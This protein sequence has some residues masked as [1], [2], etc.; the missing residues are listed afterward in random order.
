MAPCHSFL[1]A[2]SLFTLL[3]SS[4]GQSIPEVTLSSGV[5]EGISVKSPGSD[6][7]VHKYL[8]IP[9]ALPPVRFAP[10]KPL[11]SSKERKKA[12]QL[13][14]ACIQNA[15]SPDV[16][17][18]PAGESEDC[19]YLNVFTPAPITG[20]TE[21]KAVLVWIFGGGLQFGTA[22]VPTYDGTSFAANQDIVLVAI[23]YRTNVFGFPG[24]A[25]G[26][27]VD[28]QNLGFLDQRLALTWV[29]ENIAKFGGDPDKVTIFGESAGA[30]S[31]NFLILSSGPPQKPLFRAGIMQS[32]SSTLTPGGSSESKG[33][34]VAAPLPLFQQL[35][36]EVGCSVPETLVDCM[37]KVPAQRIKQTAAKAFSFGAFG[38][39]YD[40][41]RTTVLNAET[42]R[43][44]HKIANVS[45][46]IGSNADEL[47]ESIGGIGGTSRTQTLQSFV[48]ARFGKDSALKEDIKK[49]FAF[50]PS[51]DYKTEFDAV[52]A[53]STVLEFT[54]VTSRESQSSAKAGYRKLSKLIR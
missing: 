5:Y 23:N 42:A 33:K 7:V 12:T 53:L 52:A 24:P 8:G 4:N 38:A 46:L 18:A 47:K 32:G 20:K 35:G 13:P 19:L 17:P 39:T 51:T 22:S 9:F 11:G 6:T 54:C 49:A 41:G 3:G 44:G 37:R 34:G 50:G 26:L 25:P 14:S 21:P 15:P 36:R 48:D 2:L 29:Q 16:A 43:A 45:L 10:P 31:T 30:R 28:E 27:P 1:T 40:N